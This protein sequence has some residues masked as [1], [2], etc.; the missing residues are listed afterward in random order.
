MT[1]RDVVEAESVSEP[2]Q[3]PQRS[4]PDPA[5]TGTRLAWL[6]VL[7]GVA[8]LAVVFDHAS[9]YV[10][11]HVRG[12]IYQWFDPGNYGVVV[13]FIISWYIVPASLERKGR[14]RTLWVV[15]PLRLFARV[16]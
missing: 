1:S 11:Q 9:Y 14:V 2:P 7:R 13:F 12:I 5:R 8:A 10:L 4:A 3:S 16:L 6:D 15:R